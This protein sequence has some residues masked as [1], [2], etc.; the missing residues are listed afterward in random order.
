M[1]NTIK[2]YDEVK[3]FNCIH[4]KTKSETLKQ[5][6]DSEGYGILSCVDV[7][8]SSILFGRVFSKKLPIVVCIDRDYSVHLQ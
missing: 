7:R 2:Y 3:K 8:S 6:S 5:N 1:G 4:W